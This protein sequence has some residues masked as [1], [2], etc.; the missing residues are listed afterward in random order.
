VPLMLGPD[1]VRLSKRHG[2]VSL[3]AFAD[4]GMTAPRIIELLAISLGLLPSTGLMSPRDLL[5]QF[6]L[7]ALS[8][9]PATIDPATF[10]FDV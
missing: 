7:S 1:G 9:T 8:R 3:R 4:R 10:G 5:P 2:A 6:S